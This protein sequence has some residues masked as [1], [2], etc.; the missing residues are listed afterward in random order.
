MKEA[1]NST[2]IVWV[3]N[4]YWKLE[5]F[6]C[7]FVPRNKKWFEH[8][9]DK[10]KKVWDTIYYERSKEDGP[11]I[12]LYKPTKRIKSTTKTNESETKTPSD[13]VVL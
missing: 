9:I 7:I 2:N 6:S 5:K 3:K 4:T 10:I 8:S 1:E 12:D 13:V 11:N